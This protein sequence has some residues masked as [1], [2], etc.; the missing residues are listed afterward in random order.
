MPTFI[1]DL[2]NRPRPG[3]GVLDRMYQQE[4][5]VM[6]ATSPSSVEP[7]ARQSVESRRP[8]PTDQGRSMRELKK[9]NQLLA[10]LQGLTTPRDPIGGYMRSVE[11]QEGREL[12]KRSREYHRETGFGR[13]DRQMTDEDIAADIKFHDFIGTQA[14]QHRRPDRPEK[15]TQEMR[16][17]SRESREHVNV[18]GGM[19]EGM[20]KRLHEQATKAEADNAFRFAQ[21]QPR[22]NDPA[23]DMLESIQSSLMNPTH[24]ETAEQRAERTELLDKYLRWS[25]GADPV[26]GGGAAGAAGAALDALGGDV[27]VVPRSGGS[28]D[29]RGAGIEMPGWLDTLLDPRGELTSKIAGGIGRAIDDPQGEFTRDVAG[30]IGR[31]LTSEVDV[32]EPV[33]GAAKGIGSWID[34]NLMARDVRPDVAPERVFEVLNQMGREARKIDASVDRS[35]RGS[36]A[37]GWLDERLWGKSAGWGPPADQVPQSPT[38][39][40]AQ[41]PQGFDVLDPEKSRDTYLVMAGYNPAEMTEEEKEAAFAEISE[42]KGG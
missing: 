7:M 42:G 5:F 29:G 27:D 28:G 24:D 33:V 40:A 16:R 8:S 6:P 23:A 18:F 31:L 15:P 25:F 12:R 39:P 32:P 3:S 41:R 9:P 26:A 22:I 10:I 11:S 35:I 14:P 20:F 21:G 1:E 17:R 2:F 38:S 37:A 36:R 30:G 4:G 13:G 19:S 34:R